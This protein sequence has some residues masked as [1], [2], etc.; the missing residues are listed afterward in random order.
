MKNMRKKTF[1]EVISYTEKECLEDTKLVI[2]CK[3]DYLMGTIKIVAERQQKIY[4][5]FRNFKTFS[6]D[7]LSSLL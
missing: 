5:P 6:I 7:K 1:L 2:E 3:F 4:E